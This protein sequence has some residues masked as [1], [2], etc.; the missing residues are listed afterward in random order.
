M[1]VTRDDV[2]RLA[3][4]SAAT[5]SYVVNNGPRPVAEQTR[6]RVLR[7]IEQL[8]YHPSGLARSLRM[9]R[10]H[11]IGVVISDILNPT[12]AGI[13]KE[14]E[15]RVFPNDYSLI[16]C[17]SNESPQRE[18]VH[19]E[20]LLSKRV[21][22]AVLLPSGSSN[23][24]FLHTMARAQIGVV[25]V[26]R[27]ID[28]FEA[29]CVVFDNEGGMYEATQHL[30]SLGHT[31]IG[32]VNLPSGLTPGR[33]RLD[34]YLR[35]HRD[36]GLLVDYQLIAEGGFSAQA[37]Y[38]LTLG[39]L[40]LSPPP[41]ALLVSSN[42]LAQGALLQLKERGLRM[43]EDVA[44]CVFDDVPYYAF[45]TPSISA[46]AFDVRALASQAVQFL[47]E[48]ID[49]QFAGEARTAV[50]GCQLRPREST[51]GAGKLG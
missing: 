2:A 1:P 31:R 45:S 49:Q 33:G 50:I 4:V 27:H 38:A 46:V 10:T 32:L 37:G 21:D 25:L 24:D 40:E 51:L 48:R 9:Q 16:L 14:V 35:A 41:T 30:I 19:L 3:G 43:P 34:G 42:R 29:D 47:C 22:G 20:M 6:Q 18:R 8:N 15:D 36:A 11:T 28:G 13:A 39:L 26:D 23:A 17:N 7:A 12:S 44:L 5:V